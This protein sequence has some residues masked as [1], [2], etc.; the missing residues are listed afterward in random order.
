MT[1]R[2]KKVDKMTGESWK[3]YW[4]EYTADTYLYGS[5]I[6]FHDKEDVEFKNELMPPGTVVKRWYSKVN[7]QMKRVEPSLPII[8]GEGRYQIEL[9]VSAAQPEGLILK[10]VYYDR[11]DVEAGYQIVRGGS[12]KFQCPLKTY[13]YEVQLINAGAQEFHFHSIIIKEITDEE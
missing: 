10:I 1:L 12:S 11:Y 9:N 6:L 2:T 4:N 3:I 8:D 5:E 7:Y 13:S